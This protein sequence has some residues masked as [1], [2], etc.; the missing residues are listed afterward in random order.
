[1]TEYGTRS[2]STG[3][4]EPSGTK[5]RPAHGKNPGNTRRTAAASASR[6]RPGK[7][8]AHRLPKRAT[9][10]ATHGELKR[11]PKGAAGGLAERGTKGAAQ[12][13]LKRVTKRTGGRG[14]GGERS[15]EKRASPARIRGSRVD[16]G[17]GGATA[18]KGSSVRRTATQGQ[19]IKTRASKG[20]SVKANRSG[21]RLAKTRPATVG[22]KREQNKSHPRKTTRSSSRKSRS[23]ARRNAR[24]KAMNDPGS[25]TARGTVKRGNSSGSPNRLL[26]LCFSGL[27][28]RRPP[29]GLGVVVGVVETVGGQIDATVIARD[30][31]GNLGPRRG[32]TGTSILGR[33]RLGGN[34]SKSA[35]LL[36]TALAAMGHPVRIKILT[37]LLDGPGVYRSL[38]KVTGLKPGPLYHHVNQL[39]LAGLIGP[40]QRDLYELTRAGR[41][42]LL[43]TLALEPLLKDRRLRP[44]AK[45]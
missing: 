36:G 37:M 20:P 40:K 27:G 21:R 14:A 13:P 42:L 5:I 7:R 10:G 26:A 41:N 4:G 33:A 29:D 31:L 2:P 11:V 3:V 8:A 38:Q 6:G 16:G 28:R 24:R 39:R 30:R 15:T 23:N 1:M 12:R 17:S 44:Q 35:G 9:E 45:A 32:A 22:D 18:E 25:K 43:V 19:S 34:G